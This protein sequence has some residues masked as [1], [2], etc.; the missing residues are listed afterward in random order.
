MSG[1]NRLR[2][3]ALLC[4][5]LICLAAMPAF[6]EAPFA[7]NMGAAENGPV[8]FSADHLT[9]DEQTS[10]ITA[11][12]NV[13]MI[14]SGRVLKA[15]R[16]EYN[17]ATDMAKAS[18]NVV[19]RDVN[20]DTHYAD[21][22][23]LSK[24]MADGYVDHLRTVMDDGSRLW[25]V[26]GERRGGNLT[27][28]KD[29]AY[30]PCEPCKDNP[31][32]TP[33]WQIRAD[34]VEHNKE[35][36][37]MVYR[38]ATFDVG[39]VPV[40]WTPYV[41]HADGTVKQKS[42][43]LIPH[44][45]YSSD[46][47]AQISNSYYYAIDPHRDATIGITAMTQQLPLVFGEY[48]QRFNNASLEISGGVTYSGRTED[49]GGEDVKQDDE[50]RGHIKAD[51][52]WNIDE[53]WRAGIG[54]E[55]ASDDQYM[56]QYDFSDNDVLENEVYVE[57]FSGR[58]YAVGRLLSFQDIRIL[59]ER[60]D[61]P[62][63]LPEVQVSMMGEPGQ[64]LGGRWSVDLSMLN[65]I[66][67]C[68][69]QDMGRAVAQLGWNR[70]LTSDTG[71]LTT[72]DL[73]LRG[74]VYY[75]SDRDVAN[76]QAGRS[77]EGKETRGFASA[78]IVTSYPLVKNLEKSQIVIAPEGALTVSPNITSSSS[79]IPNEDSQ[80]V[81]LDASNLFS[82]D[83][84][85]GYDRIE[86]GSHVTYGVRSG[87]YGFDGSK[88]E[89]FLGQSYRL[90][91]YTNPFPRGSGLSEDA[92]DMVGQVIAQYR[93]LMDVNYRFQLDQGDMYSAR[94]EVDAYARLGA[95]TLGGRYLYSKAIEG[96]D[97]NEDREQVQGALAYRFTPE[98]QA[99]TSI[100]YDLSNEED[101]G[102]RQAVFGLDYLG[103]CF[104][105]SS[106]LER[107][108]TRD[109]SGDSG[110]EIMFRIGLKQI[111]EFSTSGVELS[112]SE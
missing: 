69:G 3:A 47:G 52:L 10:I 36:Q 67:D 46:L 111:G 28:M 21:E 39:G 94:Q 32:S 25:A 97:L 101:K 19:L 50:I 85:P 27:T 24:Q 26:R 60:R 40:F 35:E 33:V 48:R 53:K 45:G 12:G 81:Q 5:G 106:T 86:D 49:V 80:D 88:G 78:H 96:A 15:D 73:K 7:E 90:D 11:S 17:L 14:Q 42:G 59:E 56:R 38:N 4:S 74:D 83:R 66:R 103:Q 30:T 95:V 65:L 93:D 37:R 87:L 16:V 43:L 9:H 23:E 68:N 70:R 72:V 22:L 1:L 109:S 13:E 61:Q 20:G 77:G 102:M 84:F 76:G 44:F 112:G 63:V 34:E 91:D 107:N 51:G 98:W 57:R 71:L 58:N 100:L 82:D 55:I 54:L 104:T 29:A 64:S 110:T 41:S 6:A 18:G 75:T 89:V 108:L 62:S 99:R 31:D 2:K 79:N 8:D 105:F 92:S